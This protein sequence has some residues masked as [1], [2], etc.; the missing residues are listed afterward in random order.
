M[1]QKRNFQISTKLQEEQINTKMYVEE[2]KKYM[3]WRNLSV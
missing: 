3:L 2:F 1:K